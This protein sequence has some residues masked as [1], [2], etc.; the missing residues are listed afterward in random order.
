MPGY[1]LSGL[2]FFLGHRI[3]FS[4][5]N[6]TEKFLIRFEK[7]EQEYIGHDHT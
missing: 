1:Q 2:Q 5:S 7:E 6:K 4:L 3:I